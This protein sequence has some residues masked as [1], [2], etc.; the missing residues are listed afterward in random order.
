[1]CGKC[2]LKGID[3][4]CN[5]CFTKAISQAANLI[6]RPRAEI[7]RLYIALEENQK[8][9]RFWKDKT[10]TARA[11]AIKEFAQ[12]LKPKLSY[13]DEVYVDTLVKEMTEENK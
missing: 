2:N 8:A 5:T 12:R 11:E 13:Y 6:N 4:C 7:K 9:T 10:K 3:I 1:M